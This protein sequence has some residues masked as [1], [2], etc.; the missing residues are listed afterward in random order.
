MK[1]NLINLKV[2]TT[3]IG[4]FEK[5]K[6]FGLKEVLKYPL[7]PYKFRVFSRIKNFY[8]KSFKKE[9]RKNLDCKFCNQKET[10]KDSI[11][12]CNK[13]YSVIEGDFYFPLAI[14]L[15]LEDESQNSF[16][17]SSNN[18]PLLS[19][20]LCGEDFLFFFSINSTQIESFD[21]DW[22][23][24]FT[25]LNFLCS[26]NRKCNFCIKSYIPTLETKYRIFSTKLI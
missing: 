18:S 16:S 15:I 2:K 21:F 13:C 19:S 24:L 25:D 14:L 3:S 17:S 5:N 23:P 22:D 6:V 26:T 4:K 10:N 1:L 8:P 20:Y 7:V 12:Y 9:E 11:F